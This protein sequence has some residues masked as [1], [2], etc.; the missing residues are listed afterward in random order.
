M[1]TLTNYH[2]QVAK[3]VMEETNLHVAHKL[4]RIMEW[5]GLELEDVLR[6]VN[7]TNDKHH[8]SIG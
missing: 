4:E 6:L 7:I 1:A 8:P 2:V 5:T 3:E